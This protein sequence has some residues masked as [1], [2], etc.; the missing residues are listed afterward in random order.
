MKGS[1]EQDFKR[2]EVTQPNTVKELSVT[3][4][5]SPPSFSQHCKL[6]CMEEHFCKKF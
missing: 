2:T 3:R 4:V 6:T 1:Q 5:A